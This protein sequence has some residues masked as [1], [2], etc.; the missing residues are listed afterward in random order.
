VFCLKKPLD[1]MEKNIKLRS[2]SY[3]FKAAL[4]IMALWALYE[5]YLV[6][7]TSAQKINIIP[8]MVLTA[9]NLVQYFSESILKRKMIAGDEEYKEPS[10]ALRIFLAV[11]VFSAVVSFAVSF[12][13]LNRN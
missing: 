10:K 7:F 3:G 11:M 6:L 12:M 2:Q 13:I 4:L 5:S 1:E 9:L 8:C